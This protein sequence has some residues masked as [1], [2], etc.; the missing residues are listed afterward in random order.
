MF[1]LFWKENNTSAFPKLVRKKSKCSL[2]DLHCEHPGTPITLL[3]LGAVVKIC[4]QWNKIM[5]FLVYGLSI[6]LWKTLICVRV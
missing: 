6:N 5:S 1:A 2:Q 4:A 3:R